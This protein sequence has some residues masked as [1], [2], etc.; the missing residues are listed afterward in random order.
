[1]MSYDIITPLFDITIIAV[2]ADGCW[3]PL[4]LSFAIIMRYCFTFHF[5]ARI[6]PVMSYFVTF[7]YA[8]YAIAVLRHEYLLRQAYFRQQY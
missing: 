7:R 5:T 8:F 2:S 4:P 3:P 6:T 1:M